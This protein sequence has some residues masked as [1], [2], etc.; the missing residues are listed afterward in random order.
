MEDLYGASNVRMY[1]PLPLIL[2]RVALLHFDSYGKM[3]LS[4]SSGSRIVL[5]TIVPRDAAFHGWIISVPG[6]FPYL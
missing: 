2:L 6:M 4:L 1:D 5:I 3:M